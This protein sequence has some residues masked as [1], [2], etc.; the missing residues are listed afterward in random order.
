MF[1]YT[2]KVKGKQNPSFK[3]G[4]DYMVKKL[5]DVSGA[6]VFIIPTK[7]GKNLL[8]IDGYTYSQINHSVRWVCSSTKARQ[9]GARLRYEKDGTI[10]FVQTEHNHPPKLLLNHSLG[11][12]TISNIDA[13]VSV[14]KPLTE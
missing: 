13:F 2:Q 9:C 14:I 11:E 1:Y 7:R 4:L 12:Y 3:K 10:I 5:F 6:G 8:M